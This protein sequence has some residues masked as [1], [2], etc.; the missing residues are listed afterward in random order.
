[1]MVFL[2]IQYEVMCDGYNL[3]KPNEKLMKKQVQKQLKFLL[4]L[5]L[6]FKIIG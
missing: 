3:I 4:T 6:K 5:N 1:M 2:G